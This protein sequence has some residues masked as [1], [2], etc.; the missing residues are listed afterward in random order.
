M[1]CSIF[2][3]CCCY[4]FLK[5]TTSIEKIF[6]FVDQ[7]HHLDGNHAWFIFHDVEK[8]S[9][10]TWLGWFFFLSSPGYNNINRSTFNRSNFNLVQCRKNIQSKKKNDIKI[11][12]FKYSFCLQTTYKHTHRFDK[13]GYH[14]YI[15]LTIWSSSVSWTR[16]NFNFS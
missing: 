10:C 9:L 3:S 8:N 12:I 2:C 13:Y 15:S 4:F 6:Y 11:S 16:F 5:S 14:L 7:N 1:I